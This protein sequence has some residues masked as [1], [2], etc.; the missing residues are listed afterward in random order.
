MERSDAEIVEA[1][2]LSNEGPLLNCLKD[3][4][5]FV[6]AVKNPN[7][8]YQQTLVL[9]HKLLKDLALFEHDI[10]KLNLLQT[11]NSRQFANYNQHK[12]Q[13]ESSERVAMAEIGELYGE[14]KVAQVK[15]SHE[16]EY[17]AVA[18]IINQLPSRKETQKQVEA[19]N[20]ELEVLGN[21]KK[22]TAFQIDI[23][24]KQFSLFFHAL[25]DLKL[26]WN[27]FQADT[28][29]QNNIL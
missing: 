10:N 19:L 21:E 11:A 7:A 2:F 18:K 12:R 8:T 6:S 15:R 9:Y 16:E 4:T 23:K 13:I 1:R 17:E 26:N 22:S 29:H 24:R 14:L 28:Q 3:Y 25:N 20:D 5:L 27:F